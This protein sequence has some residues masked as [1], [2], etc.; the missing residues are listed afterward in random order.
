MC[1]KYPPDGPADD[2]LAVIEGPRVAPE[3]ALALCQDIVRGTLDVHGHGLPIG[4]FNRRECVVAERVL[5]G[6][7]AVDLPARPYTV[8][9]VREDTDKCMSDVGVAVERF[10]AIV[11]KYPNRFHKD[12]AHEANVAELFADGES[13]MTN[14]ARAEMFEMDKRTVKKDQNLAAAA[15]VSMERNSARRMCS[16]VLEAVEALMGRGN[17]LSQLM[18]V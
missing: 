16:Q 5:L 4:A 18:H 14:V 10:S 2:V 11:D 15:A 17:G 6:P 1:L 7:C 8:T 9:Q 13:L 12:P 3:D